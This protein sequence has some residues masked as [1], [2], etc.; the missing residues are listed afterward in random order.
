[1]GMK[2]VYSQPSRADNQL[3]LNLH[4]ISLDSDLIKTQ[5]AIKDQ[6]TNCDMNVCVGFP[7]AQFTQGEAAAELVPPFEIIICLF[8]SFFLLHV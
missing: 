6:T 2:L 4:L 5:S 7:G 8:S 1:M 3:S